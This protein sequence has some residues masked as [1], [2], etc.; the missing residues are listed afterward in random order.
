MGTVQSVTP[1]VYMMKLLLV[2]VLVAVVVANE[3]DA[4]YGHGGRPNRPH[5]GNRPHLGANRPFQQPGNVGQNFANVPF[6]PGT[7][8]GQGGFGQQ[9]GFGGHQGLLGQGG[10]GQ[11]GFGQQGLLGQGGHGQQGFG[12]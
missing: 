6:P 7:V 1:P 11:Q 9:G 8:G 4:R 12:Q 10:H 5:Q 3:P 2:S